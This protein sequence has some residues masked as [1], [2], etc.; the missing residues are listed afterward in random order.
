MKNPKGFGGVYKMGGRRRNP[1]AARKTIGYNDKGNQVF[2]YIGYYSSRRAAME[3]LILANLEKEKKADPIISFREAFESW[4]VRK[5]RQW[6]E[7]TK[8][9]MMSAYNKYCSIYA[10][11]DIKEL[12]E[13]DMQTVVDECE[14]GYQTK[15][16]IKQV[17]NDTLDLAKARGLIDRNEAFLLYIG[18][19]GEPVRPHIPFTDE[20][21]KLLWKNKTMPWVDSV[22][23]MI[24]S[25]YRINEMLA[26][27]NANIDPTKMLSTGGSK[28]SAGK[29]RTVPLSSKLEVLVKRRYAKTREFLF[30]DDNGEKVLYHNYM[31]Y[32][33][34]PVMDALGLDHTPHDCRH[35]IVTKLQQKDVK[36]VIV[37]KIVGHKPKDVTDGVY[38]HI[39]ID[40]MR[41]AIE[42]L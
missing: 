4:F 40:E 37:Q 18:E 42:L 27:K 1:W 29:N 6:S 26:L 28:T 3:A 24:Y 23:F 39:T 22:L 10:D 9:S 21:I 33:W 19:Q 15:S 34:K 35:T 11:I 17:F 30:V 16:K 36:K 41:D 14:S 32:Y 8:R 5:E 25:G 7:N 12:T 2:E 38:T 31:K 20:E 13:E